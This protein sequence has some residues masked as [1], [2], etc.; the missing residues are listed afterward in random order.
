[1][2]RS[3]AAPAV[4]PD[5]C[6]SRWR[7]GGILAMP[8][9]AMPVLAMLAL[10]L[11]ACQTPAPAPPAE[12][13]VPAPAPEVVPPVAALPPEPVIDD[14]P[15]RLMGLDPLRLNAILGAPELIRREPPAEIWQYRGASCV[16]DV[17]FYETAGVRIVTYLEARDEA[18]Q[19]TAERGC[20][21]EL[22][23]A[24]LNGPLG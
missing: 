9:L 8:V 3:P 20:L 17:F 14:N 12:S 6:L 2:I 21:N 4:R 16:F 24:R 15:Q 10:A 5:T 7:R 13:A 18:A 19:R 23:R 1:V 22:L 11:G